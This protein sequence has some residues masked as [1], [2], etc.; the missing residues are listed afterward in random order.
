[1][2]TET[3]ITIFGR[4]CPYGRSSTWRR[5]STVA[6]SATL[7]RLGDVV[8][9]APDARQFRVVRFAGGKAIVEAI[10]G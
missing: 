10:I 9:E 1:M 4:R 5:V 2:P 3:T 7:L 8:S 6:T